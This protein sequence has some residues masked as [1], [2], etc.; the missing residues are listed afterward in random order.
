MT[1]QLSH[2]IHQ[3]LELPQQFSMANVFRVRLDA[4]KSQ[5]PTGFEYALSH[6]GERFKTLL[7]GGGF[8]LRHGDQFLLQSIYMHFAIL[9]QY[10]RLSFHDLVQLAM[11]IQESHH[12]IVD[13]QER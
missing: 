5:R 12:E 1:A 10:I 4:D 7:A 11:A 8:Q 2:F 9:D 6:F 13:Q 3:P